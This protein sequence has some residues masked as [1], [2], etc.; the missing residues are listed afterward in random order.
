MSGALW[1]LAGA[2][3]GALITFLIAR[4]GRVSTPEPTALPPFPEEILGS[5]TVTHLASSLV[6][7]S[8]FE[9]LALV[10]VERCTARAGLPAALVMREKPGGPAAIT[11]VASGLDPRLVGVPVDLLS[12]AGRALTEGIPVVGSPEERVVDRSRGDR[13]RGQ[14]GGIAVPISQGGR[15]Y[16]AVLTFG[17]PS[18]GAATAVEG[19]AEEVRKFAP[20]IIPAFAAVAAG[21]RAETDDLTQLA[22]R[23]GLNAAMARS[24]NPGR[25][26]LVVI[27]LDHFKSVNDTHGHQAG[28]AALKQVARVLRE[29]IR[30]R[31]TAARIG[32]EEFAIWLPG[33][34]LEAGREV[35]ERVR[36]TVAASPLRHAGSEQL[37]TV[38]CGV[39]AYPKPIRPLENLMGAADAALYAAKRAGRNKV[40]ASMDPAG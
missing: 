1:F 20:V 26:A 35:A 40:V 30:P 24:G 16:G 32:G 3:V 34:D 2:L 39:A 36:A 37:L 19:L 11:T 6:T 28:D 17:T 31:D 23:R 8:T 38:S 21:R 29:T 13:R 4:R 5:D 33:A 9:P 18:S 22:N 14:G 15:V 7:D 12:T 10:L 27:D 25:A